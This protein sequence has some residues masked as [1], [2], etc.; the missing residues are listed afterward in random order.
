MRSRDTLRPASRRRRLSSAR[1]PSSSAR[2][3]L[4]SSDASAST[5]GSLGEAS[6]D[7]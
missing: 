5:H 2:G 4:T 6:S 3:M 1:N 7:V